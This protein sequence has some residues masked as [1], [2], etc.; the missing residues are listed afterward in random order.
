MGRTGI[1]Y[2]LSG[3][4]GAGKGTVLRKVLEQLNNLAVSVSVTTRAP[5]EGEID[6][7][8]YCFKSKEEFQ[9]MVENDEFLEYVN[10]FKNRY[11]TPKAQVEKLIAN[12][13]DVVLEIETNGAS[14][15]RKVFPKACL[16]FITP[17][18]YSELS[19]R[20]D[21]RGSETEETK[22]LRLKI[23]RREYK[24]M[25]HYNYVAVNDDID[26]C[27]SAVKAIIEAERL[28]IKRNPAI[29]SGFLEQINKQ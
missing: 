17:S 14:K 29:I 7:I 3:P 5:R 22:A 12:G 9:A 6:G 2:V 10:K 1:L 16:I 8:H 11:G 27:V 15:V 28:R 4:S 18:S 24:C 26:E 23:A 19:K 21:C 13:T 25:K 20:L